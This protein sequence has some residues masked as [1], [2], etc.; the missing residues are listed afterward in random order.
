MVLSKYR[1]TPAD[2]DVL[3]AGDGEE[4]KVWYSSQLIAQAY[5]KVPQPVAFYT[6]TLRS[7]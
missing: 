2:T 6:H 7:S 5:T 4:K 3:Q 1:G